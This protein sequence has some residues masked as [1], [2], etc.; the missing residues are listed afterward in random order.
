MKKHNY[1]RVAVLAVAFFAAAA[2][3]QVY[4]LV[5]ADN[6]VT[7]GDDFRVTPTSS[8]SAIGTGE[9]QVWTIEGRNLQQIMFVGDRRNGDPLLEGVLPGTGMVQSSATFEDDLS[10]VELVERYQSA[11]SEFGFTDFEITETSVTDLAGRAAIR[12][13]FTARRDNLPLYRGTSLIVKNDTSAHSATYIAAD[14]YYFERHH[15]EFMNMMNTVEW[16][17]SATL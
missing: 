10:V 9:I 8:W 17:D 15:A 14:L 6:G 7:I 2:C 4:T 16:L 12:L 3:Q 13:D 5:S 11:F 1:F